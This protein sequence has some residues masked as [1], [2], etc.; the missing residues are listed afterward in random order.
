MKT[1][2][3]A[4]LSGIGMCGPYNLHYTL[5]NAQRAARANFLLAAFARPLTASRIARLHLMS[6]P[7]CQL[8]SAPSNVRR[9]VERSSTQGPLMPLPTR[10]APRH[11]ELLVEQGCLGIVSRLR[12]ADLPF[13]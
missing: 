10:P 9:P 11:G 4:L 2:S 3:L 12:R 6:Y 1:K 5:A 8:T 13:T 7:R